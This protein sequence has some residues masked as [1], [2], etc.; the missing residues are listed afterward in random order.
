MRTIYSCHSLI[1]N[2]P[3]QQVYLQRI[4]SKNVKL[5]K[6]LTR[7]VLLNPGSHLPG[8]AEL[9]RH[10]EVAECWGQ[11]SGIWRAQHR[12]PGL[13]L[14]LHGKRLNTRWSSWNFKSWV[15]RSFASHCLT[16]ANPTGLSWL[17]AVGAFCFH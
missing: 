15:G 9:P 10:A 1:S 5:A 7:I 6:H 2:I 4:T 14:G 16:M 12:R 11:L 3:P 8:G 13:L 17:S